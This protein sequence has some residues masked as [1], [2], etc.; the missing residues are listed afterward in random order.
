MRQRIFTVSTNRSKLTSSGNVHKKYL[1]GWAS[2]LGHSMSNHSS[3]TQHLTLCRTHPLSGKPR[4]EPSVRAFAPTHGAIGRSG[5]RL[6]D[7]QCTDWLMP[8]IAHRALTT[9]AALGLRRH[10]SG[11]MFAPPQL[12]LGVDAGGGT[13]ADVR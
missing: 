4:R 5:Q 11:L 13:E 6:C 9:R 1:V 12:R 10:R 3:A 8:R 7:V 2:A